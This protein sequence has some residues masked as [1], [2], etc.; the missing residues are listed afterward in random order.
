[1]LDTE[2]ARSRRYD[3][4]WSV[5]LLDVDGFRE[6]NASGGQVTG[7][8]VLRQVAAAIEEASRASDLAARIGGDEFALLLP[9][10]SAEASKLT[11]RR[12]AA[13]VAART[14]GVSVSVGT[15]SWPDDGESKEL[16]LLRADMQL[17]AAKPLAS[18][19]ANAAGGPSPSPGIRRILSLAREQLGMDVAY[20]AELTPESQVIHAV[21]GDAGSFGVEEGSELPLEATY[22]RR[23]LE[24]RIPSAVRDT[25]EEPE[26]SALPITAQ[27]GVGSY[28]GVPLELSGGR[29]YGTLCCVS[30]SPNPS[31][32]ERHVELMGFL[33]SLASDQIE[34]EERELTDRRSHVELAGIHALLSALTARDHYTGE[35]SQTVVRLATG[36]ARRLALTED[37]VAEV[38]QVALLHDIGKVGVPDSVLQ[39]RGSLN[40]QEWELMRQHPAIGA[41]ILADTETLSHLAA[42]VKAEHERFDGSGYPDGLRGE[43]IPLASRITLACDAYHAMT[44]DRPYRAALGPEIA[45]AELRAGAGTQFDPSVVGALLA[46]IEADAAGEP[47]PQ[48]AREAGMA[49][50]SANV[51]DALLPRMTP[52]WERRGGSDGASAL[53]EV[54]AAC[55]RCGT[56]VTATVSSATLSGVC[57]NCGSYEL[58]LLES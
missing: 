1:M 27:A 14:D 37:R 58:D 19:G 2:T 18:S 32:V 17:Q 8:R 50:L 12:I 47:P 36:V 46:Q 55:R 26:L 52:A 23:L 13:A 30:H 11:A 54:R 4:H 38:E 34:R 56:H 6:I 33:A 20:L 45:A 28:L 39:K 16:V 5:V 22:C 41:R 29:V 35:H 42:A 24:G 3:A 10:T 15:A 31:L 9:E 44:S 7:D 43:A 25:A 48:P 40:E 53:G 57:G 49:G 51:L 21:S